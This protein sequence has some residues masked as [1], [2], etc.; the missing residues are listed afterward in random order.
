MSQLQYGAALHSFVRREHGFRL[1][2][3]PTDRRHRVALTLPATER[4]RAIQAASMAMNT[5]PPAGRVDSF[6]STMRQP[7]PP[8]SPL[9]PSAGAPVADPAPAPA[10]AD[11]APLSEHAPAK[12]VPPGH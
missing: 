6:A 4:R 2:G 10:V 7:Q 12:Q 5:R 11:P 8:S 1:L 9:V 3:C